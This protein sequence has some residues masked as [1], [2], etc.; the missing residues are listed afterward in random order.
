MKYKSINQLGLS[1]RAYNCLNNAG[2]KTIDDMLHIDLKSLKN[3]GVKTEEEIN[4]KILELKEKGYFYSN[5]FIDKKC[6]NQYKD[7][8]GNTN[9]DIFDISFKLKDKLK[10]KQIV[11][12]QD[13]I[14]N[15]LNDCGDLSEEYNSF[16]SFFYNIVYGPLKITISEEL[17]N[18]YIYVPFNIS[19]FKQ[20]NLYQIKEIINSGI[21]N[22]LDL[23]LEEK[24]NLKL[25]LYWIN[26]FEIDNIEKYY[27]EIL[28]LTDRQKEILS[29]RT[30]MTL[31]EVGTLF[32]VTRER[33]R[34]IESKLIEKTKEKYLSIPFKYL[35]PLKIYYANDSTSF[36]MLMMFF[37]T[38]FDSKYSF[39]SNSK[40]YMPTYY[41][42]IINKLMEENKE[43]IEYDGYL[44]FNN[45]I[46]DDLFY[47]SIE[48]LNLNYSNKFIS[49]KHTKRMQVKYALRYIGHPVSISNNDDQEL[50]VKTVKF[51]F[52]TDLE[53]GR[54]LEA[55]ITDAGVRVDSG[56]YFSDDQIIPLPVEILNEIKEYV[57]DK[58]IINTRD[59]FVKYGDILNKHNLNNEVIL[60]RYLK[61]KLS[62]ELFFHGISAVISSNQD[63]GSWGDLAIKII[64]ENNKPIKKLDFMVKY[65][66]TDAVYTNLPI[67]FTDIIQWSS[68]ELYLKS[69]IK[70]PAELMDKLVNF[71]SNKQIVSFDEI[72]TI[73]N[74]YDSKLLLENNVFSS[75][76]LYNFLINIFENNYIVDKYSKE[77]R[78]VSKRKLVIDD[79]YSET[80]ELTI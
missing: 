41:V 30:Y 26:S 5:F 37:S 21:K 60:Y 20:N 72:V 49:K 55:L 51:L 56:M 80:E 40:Y 50:L 78:C 31:E 42:D 35:N 44:E 45:I 10:E 22:F 79:K 39:I 12:L 36:E 14:L 25:Y 11:T 54:S 17:K 28:D 34:Q 43:T 68:R 9:V 18:L 63:L 1:V 29:K 66:I 23:T 69:M 27:L 61:E 19:I 57:K 70:M 77:V 4:N 52:G 47:K 74:N 64:K 62:N 7:F 59:L 67:N 8:C 33:I 24:I 46:Y 73:I 75:D 3:C 32:G 6:M 65:S 38:T 53:K 2:V 71:I 13:L 76:N 16:Y 15:K 58:K 48:Y